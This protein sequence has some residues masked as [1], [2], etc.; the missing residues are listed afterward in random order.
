MSP[1]GEELF[2]EYKSRF[3]LLENEFLKPK[4][5]YKEKKSGFPESELSINKEI[6]YRRELGWDFGAEPF[7]RST[8]VCGLDSYPE[9][10]RPNGKHWQKN[11]KFLK[12]FF[13]E[14]QKIMLLQ[15]F[16]E[17]EFE[18]DYFKYAVQS[19]KGLWSEYLARRALYNYENE[20][21]RASVKNQEELDCGDLLLVAPNISPLVAT[22]AMEPQFKKMIVVEDLQPA[23]GVIFYLENSSISEVKTERKLKPSERRQIISDYLEMLFWEKYFKC[24]HY[25]K[26]ACEICER[27][28]YP[29]SSWEY[30][31]VGAVSPRYCFRC[32]KMAF[33]SS[34][35]FFRKLNFTNEQRLQNWKIGLLEFVNFFGFVPSSNL[36]KRKIFAGLNN[37]RVEKD[38]M[39]EAIKIAA[40]L[41]NKS[42]VCTQYKSWAHFLADCNQ[43][44]KVGVFGTQ[45]IA[46]DGHHCL[47]FGERAICETLTKNKLNHD[48]EPY[49]PKDSELN[50]N[51]GMRADFK[52]GDC[53]IEFAGLMTRED[54]KQK[55]LIKKELA[56]RHNI[57]LLVIEEISIET[58]DSLVTELQNGKKRE[59]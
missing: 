15:V 49:Y 12:G 26:Q 16:N 3:E 19:A 59:Y 27:S 56:T 35:D 43:L 17:T 52:V 47:S 5:S 54:Y 50:P 39:K 7:D 45:S 24:E 13:S 44:T 42:E 40:L 29:Q 1:E 30:E 10:F 31:W 55:M 21:S 9:H 37:L 41:P 20:D 22:L 36:G 34:S 28:F 53:L 33:S 32:L 6:Y 51:G 4:I 38:F 25:E 57:K 23:N 2:N 46:S 58:L 8:H 14:E 11:W 48:K 18:L